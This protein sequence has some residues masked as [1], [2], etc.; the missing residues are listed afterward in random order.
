MRAAAQVRAILVERLWERLA[1]PALADAT[2]GAIDA[3]AAH[4]LDP[5]GAAD[6]LLA[7]LGNAGEEQR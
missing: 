6:R 1:M 2:A 4:E 7:A 5:Y 3:V